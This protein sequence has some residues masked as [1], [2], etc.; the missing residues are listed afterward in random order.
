MKTRRL[1]TL[2][3]PL[4]TACSDYD[5]SGKPQ[6][7]PID[8][9]APPVPEPTG[10]VLTLLLTM[11]DDWMDL[12]ISEK[13]L[14]NSAAWLLDGKDGASRVL[15]VRDDNYSGEDEDDSAFITTTLVQAGYD[16]TLV[17]EPADGLQEADLEGYEAAILSNPGHSPDDLSTLDALYAFSTQ[18]H[19]IVFQGDDMAHFEDPAAFDM[20]SLTRL[21]YIDNGTEYGGHAIDNDAGEAYEVTLGMG[22]PITEGL[23]GRQFRYGN[24]IDTTEIVSDSLTVVAVATVE[25]TTLDLKPVIAA[26]RP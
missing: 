22:H 8:T 1:T 11:S 9:A 6:D 20:S 23:E 18:G 21:G 5:F 16:A 24:D 26:W 2:L 17:E 3:L 4:L 19:G 13:I 10:R 7:L 15:V 14:V 25:N 12:E